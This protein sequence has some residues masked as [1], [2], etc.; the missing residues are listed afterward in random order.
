MYIKLKSH[1]MKKKL[2]RAGMGI[3]LAV[4]D[5]C[6]LKNQACAHPMIIVL[7]KA[8]SQI[9]P[10]SDLGFP[11]SIPGSGFSPQ[12]IDVD[13]LSARIYTITLTLFDDT[14]KHTQNSPYR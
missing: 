12:R 1:A 8:Q 11:S 9:S 14:I 10:G 4:L 3:L 2:L 6:F 5:I 7:K 13:K